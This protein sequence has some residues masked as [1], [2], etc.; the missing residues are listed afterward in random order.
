MC[1]P[2]N[3]TAAIFLALR[4]IKASAAAPHMCC[5]HVHTSGECADVQERTDGVTA[6]SALCVGMGEGNMTWLK[7]T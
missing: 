2:K 4:G 3:S 7:V 6:P 5:I 1:L